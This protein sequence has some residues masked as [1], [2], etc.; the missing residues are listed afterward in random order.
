MNGK[1]LAAIVFYAACAQAAAQNVYRC[2]D[3]Y[4]QQPCL[5]GVMVPA[6]D[7]RSAQQKAEAAAAA[8]R[9]AK[10]AEALE[11]ERLKQEAQPVPAYSPTPKT[12]P[13]PESHRPVMSTPQKPPVFRAVAPARPDDIG[14]KK[15]KGKKKGKK[16]KR[17]RFH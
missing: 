10:A 1:Q 2:G 11:K 7:A 5:G 15:K 8:R 13:A 14:P 9:D 6:E 4:S 17:G 3:S 16:H 12:E